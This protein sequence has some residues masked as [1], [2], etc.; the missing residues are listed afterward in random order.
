[1]PTACVK[2]SSLVV[3]KE[4]LRTWK[5]A[6][7]VAAARLRENGFAKKLQQELV[8]E[9]HVHDRAVVALHELLDRESVGGIFVAESTCQLDLM[10][11]E[12]AVLVPPGHQ[13]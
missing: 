6:L 2:H 1:V 4:P 12:Q 10:V 7:S 3:S 9:A 8:Q 13:V 11:K 5:R